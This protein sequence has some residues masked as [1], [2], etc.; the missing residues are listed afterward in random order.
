MPYINCKPIAEKIEAET[1][2]FISGLHYIPELSIIL[3]T[4]DQ[5]AEIYARSITRA[6]ER[7]GIHISV[8]RWYS[9]LEPIT[10]DFARYHFEKEIQRSID[11]VVVLSDSPDLLWLRDEIPKNLN[12]EGDDHNDNIDLLFCTAL[13]CVEVIESVQPLEGLD[14][15]VVGYGKRVGKPL[16]YLLMRKHVGSVTTTHKYTKSLISH[17]QRADVIISAVGKP[18]IITPE[19]VKPNALVIDVG[20]SSNGK[21]DVLS[22]V[23]EI[24]S[25]TPVPGGIGPITTAIL[26]RNVARSYYRR[27]SK[28]QRT[29]YE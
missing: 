9:C 27:I 12:V 5:S 19:M 22:T 4:E 17:T 14:V 6:A 15:V 10:R 13:A 1:K 7:V 23:S 8:A 24:A 25:V 26:L 29:A 20:C 2:S 16:S 18:G 28:T 11:G 21:G 3:P